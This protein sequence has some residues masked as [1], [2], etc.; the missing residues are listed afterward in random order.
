TRGLRDHPAFPALEVD[1]PRFGPAWKTYTTHE[2]EARYGP[3]WEMAA[4][5]AHDQPFWALCHRREFYDR[6]DPDEPGHFL[7]YDLIYPNGYGEALSGGEREWQ[8]D[9]IRDRI[10]RDPI[11]AAA[12]AAY[13]EI[14]HGLVSSAGGGLGIERLLR[15]LTRSP[16]VGDVQMFRRVPGEEGRA[17][18]TSPSNPLR[19]S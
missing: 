4:S 3:N 9:R 10:S 19:T 16:H 15:F 6:E 1:P 2:L 7:N 13:L 11:P 12:L 18:N 17:V 5:K 8:P 14:A